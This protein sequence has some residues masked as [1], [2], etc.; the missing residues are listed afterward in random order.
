MRARWEQAY[1]DRPVD[2]VI[3]VDTVSL[4]YLIDATGPITVQGVRLTGDNLTEELLS[5]SYARLTQDEQDAFFAEVA[6][7]AFERFTTGLSDGTGVVK[8]LARG[9][10][11]G[12]ILLHSFDPDLQERI[13]G[14]RIA[15][16][17]MS[18]APAGR[19]SIAITLNDT[20][21]A[22][23]SYYLRYQV[24]ASATYC[25]PQQ[26][27]GFALKAHLTSTAPPDAAT[28]LPSYV[29]GNQGVRKGDELVTV[30]FFGPVGGSI[31]DLV[32]NDQPMPLI[33]TTEDG[34]PVAMTYVELMPGQTVDLSLTMESG[35]DQPGDT[36]VTV[37]PTIQPSDVLSTLTSACG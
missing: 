16:D 35:A 25:T 27:Q 9:V 33:R 28:S 18:D 6:R 21:A 24:D 11:E 29:T 15:G 13:A 7:T 8:A 3:L 5:R 22:K 23:M 2:G 37:T 14:S 31:G 10:E 30:R 32:L 19:P 1:P 36:Q 17:L 4:G 34:R 26:G 20:T 12:R